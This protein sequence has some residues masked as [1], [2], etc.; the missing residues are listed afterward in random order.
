MDFFMTLPMLVMVRF[1]RFDELLAEPRPDP[2]YPVLTGLWL[3]THGIALA[4]KGRLAEARAI[5]G[6]LARLIDDI[7][8]T[9]V[10][11]TNKSRDL[12]TVGATALEAA[13]AQ[14]AGDESTHALW[15]SA[16][17]QADR[18]SYNEP[19]DW[20]YPVRHYQGAALIAAKRYPEAEAVYRADLA[21]NPNNGW[22]LTGLATAL[23][24]QGRDA[25]TVRSAVAKAWSN[26]DMEIRSS[27]LF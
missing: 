5:H 12:I 1:G 21:H 6:E 14:K 9:M 2:K 7:P 22:A 13:I 26:A 16:V 24:G 25:R 27:A 4:A 11:G 15:A 19:A 10:S 3:H 8:E 18:L 23:E 17:E 20:F